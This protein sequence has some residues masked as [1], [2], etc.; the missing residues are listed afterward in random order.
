MDRRPISDSIRQ[1]LIGELDVWR[2]GGILADDQTARILD[3]Y[4]TSTESAR[5]RRSLA[6]FVLSSMAALMI[7]LAVLLVVAYN[8]HEMPAAAKLAVIFGALLAS[9]AT[10][11][12]LRFQARRPRTSEI[13]FFLACLFYGAAIWLIAQIFNI[14]SHYPDA[15]LVLGLGRVAVRPVP[16]HVADAC[17]LCRLAGEL[18]GR[19]RFWASR[20]WTPGC[21]MG[22]TSPTPR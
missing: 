12:C 7:G 8:W 22:F 4:E 20:A 1:W 17:P 9:Y 14:Q 5:R 18:G 6:M 21:F 19:R 16:R 2:A 15:L 11:F 3:L 13:V 10:G